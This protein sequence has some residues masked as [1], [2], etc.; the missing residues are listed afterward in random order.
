MFTKFGALNNLCKIHTEWVLLLSCLSMTTWSPSCTLCRTFIF[1]SHLQKVWT[2]HSSHQPWHIHTAVTLSQ[3]PQPVLT[4]VTFLPAA[5]LHSRALFVHFAVRI[6]SFSHIQK[7]ELVTLFTH[8][9][10]FT[11]LWYCH[12]TRKPLSVFAI[13]LPAGV[14]HSSAL[15]VHFALRFCSF[16][17]SPKSVNPAL[18]SPILTHSHYCDT[19]T[20]LANQ[21]CLRNLSSCW[22]ILLERAIR[23]LCRAF[24][25]FSSSPKRVNPSHFSLPLTDSH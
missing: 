14:L 21:A 19:I 13:F 17:P 8:L 23:T 22:C 18:F 9:E 2:R 5:L 16:L 15:F 20:V 25:Y 6:C 24:L 10:T 11:L 3:S 12:N 4:V 7:C 1:I